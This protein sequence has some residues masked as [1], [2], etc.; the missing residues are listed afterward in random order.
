MRPRVA[1]CFTTL[2]CLLLALTA[3]ARAQTFSFVSAFTEDV[4]KPTGLALDTIGGVTYLY[5]SDHDG[6]RV[7]KYNLNDGSRVLI[8]GRGTADGQFLWPDAIAVEPV[9]HDLYIADRQLHRITRLT[10]TGAFVMKWGDTGTQVNRFGHPRAGSAA[11]QFNGPV[12][13]AIDAN[14]FLYTTEHENHRVQKFRV[15][16]AGD[17]WNVETITTWGSGGSGPGQFNTP[18][19]IAVDAAGNIWV[20]DGFNS[21]LQRFTPSGQLLSQIVVRGAGE[22]HL[23]NT[24]VTF[25]PEGNVYAAITSDPNTGGDL[26]NQR[27][28]KF[29]PAGVSLA[30]WGARGVGP[31]QF[32]LPFGLA[33]DAATNRAYV[34]DYDNR[35]VQVFALGPQ[36]ATPA[37]PTPTTPAPNTSAPSRLANLSSRQRVVVDGSRTATAGFVITGTSPRPVLVRAVGPGLAPFGVNEIAADP[38]L[39]LFD[40]N[41]RAIAANDNWGGTTE[42]A[43]AAERVGAFPLANGSRDAALLA[44]LAPGNYTAL[45]SAAG[46]AGVLLLEIYDASSAPP[47]AGDRLI[48]VSLRGFVDTGEARLVAGFVIAGSAAKRVLVR[49][50]GPALAAFGVSG[51]LADPVLQVFASAAA[52]PVAQND[53]W[54]TPQP[55]SGGGAAAP[56]S[57]TEISAASRAAGAFALAAGSRDAAVV[58]TL[59]PGNYTAVLGGAGN[60]TGEGLVEVFELPER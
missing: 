18:Y 21:R 16:R 51:V 28:E 15:S 29:S 35:R 34:T 31:G 59:P 33:I 17:A 14:G 40:G 56:A 13:I 38:R 57:A 47:P 26:A 11:G 42:L 44:T 8:A 45:A 9:T 32:Q 55:V 27:I 2:V 3:A 4:G 46:G 10:N 43:A 49:G 36:G 37:T 23:V 54:D 5:V 30:K 25:D 41:S 52:S 24:W 7:F 50:V 48:N 53:N 58:L 60:G 1:S 22:P 12:G 6:G 19:G 20:A 39:Q